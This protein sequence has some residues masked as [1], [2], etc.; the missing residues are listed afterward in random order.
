MEEILLE[1]VTYYKNQ[2]SKNI[3]K[4]LCDIFGKLLGITNEN[5]DLINKI[6]N[7]CHN[8]SLVIDDIEDNSLLRRN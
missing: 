7:D 4:I 3:R 2:K 5:I 1:P 6:T 8:A